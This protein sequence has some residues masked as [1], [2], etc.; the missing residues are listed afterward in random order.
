MLRFVFVISQ[1]PIDFERSSIEIEKE[2]YWI[3]IGNP[4]TLPENCL[5]F[6]KQSLILA[7]NPSNFSRKSIEFK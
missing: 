5:D 7:G 4:S 3:G 2:I 1:E 6:N